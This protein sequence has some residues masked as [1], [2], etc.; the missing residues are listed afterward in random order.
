MSI[1]RRSGRLEI[2]TTEFIADTAYCICYEDYSLFS[3]DIRF[4]LHLNLTEMPSGVNLPELFRSNK[5]IDTLGIYRIG[6]PYHEEDSEPTHLSGEFILQNGQKIIKLAPIEENFNTIFHCGKNSGE[7]LEIL[8]TRIGDVFFVL[9]YKTMEYCFLSENIK[10]LTGYTADEVKQLGFI[11]MVQKV[12]IVKTLPNSLDEIQSKGNKLVIKEYLV[13]TA[14]GESKW[15][16]ESGETIKDKTG[17][18]VGFF[19]RYTDIDNEKKTLDK[20]KETRSN[21]NIIVQNVPIGLAI[22]QND[23]VVFANSELASILNA[24]SPE[25]II[26]TPF[27]RFCPESKRQLFLGMYQ[28]IIERKEKFENITDDFYDVNGKLTKIQVSSLPTVYNGRPAVQIIARSL[29]KKEKIRKIRSTLTSILEESYLVDELSEFYRYIHY[30]VK[31]LIDANSFFIAMINKN[32]RQLEFNYYYDEL[33]NDIEFRQV[34]KVLASVVVDKKHSLIFKKSHISE[35]LK[36]HFREETPALPESWL[37]VPLKLSDEVIGLMAAQNYHSGDIYREFEREL[38]ESIAFTISRVIERKIREEEKQS[39]ITQLENSNTGKDKLFSVLSHDLRSPF[40]S[41]QGYI[42]ILKEDL[43]ELDHSEVENIL[44]SISEISEGIRSQLESLLEYSRFQLGKIKTAPEN[45][46]LKHIIN[47]VVKLFDN[48]IKQKSLDVSIGMP[49]NLTVFMDPNMLRSIIQ[50]LLSNSIKF[51]H[52][53]GKIEISAVKINDEKILFTLLDYGVGFKEEDLNE[54][55]LTG[56][57]KSRKGTFEELGTGFGLQIVQD[58]I[59]S[60]DQSISIRNHHLGGSLIEFT[61]PI[62]R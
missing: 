34:E 28:A 4:L 5:I 9:E 44:Q 50:N 46:P 54:F 49:D 15:I 37:G 55:K 56:K 10:R 47:S 30:S 48:Q 62:G 39:L 35:L 42:Q 57:I 11:S 22:V 25:D 58:F 43:K 29:S 32:T 31:E 12:D 6:S 61:L 7:L 27:V 18:S 41:L 17:K 52:K 16:R 38:M 13:R 1:V 20:L 3:C 40:S 8:S 21:L 59:Q 60:L 26:N 19:G 23:C 36:K 33:G 45:L 24:S 2:S 53:S 51:S 14:S